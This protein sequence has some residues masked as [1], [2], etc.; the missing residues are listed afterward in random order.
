MEIRDKKEILALSNLS[1]KYKN[2]KVLENI[3]LSINKGEF[4]LLC[5]ESGSG[6]TTLLKVFNTVIPN[7]ENCDYEGEV[8]IAGIENKNL[9]EV[10]KKVSTVFQNPK[11]HF[12]N[13]DT[14]LELVFFLEN[15]GVKRDLIDEKIE[16][17]LKIFPIRHLL[18]RSIFNLS[19]G[20][21]Q[22]LAIAGAYIADT[23]IIIFDEPSANLDIKHIEILRTMLEKLKSLGK[24]III[25]EHRLW[26]LKDL[27]DRSIYIKN[28]KI[29]KEFSGKDF[30]ELSDEQR[31]E[32]GLKS[33]EKKNVDKRFFETVAKEKNKDEQNLKIKKLEYNFENKQILTISDLKYSFG[34]IIGIVGENGTG[35]STFLASLVGLEKKA[36]LDIEIEN[37]K[38]SKKE[39]I[40][41]S[42]LVMQDVNKQLFT[43]SVEQ[44]V[45]MNRELREDEINNVLKQMDLLD[46]KDRHPHSLSGGQN[47]ELLFLK[48]FYLRQKFYVL[49]SLQ[50]VWITRICS[51]YLN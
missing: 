22:I 31:K 50:V 7:Y 33:L 34:E 4:I 37:K 44:E 26:F 36:K 28:G 35:K 10:S 25:A 23:D 8:F 42:S 18:N 39:L 32:M 43:E 41:L 14:T 49:M 47:R 46:F 20:E 30:F 6:K 11:T 48:P 19:G 45:S 3:N 1:L 5:G 24:T 38:N 9:E 17:M 21:K 15:I 29:E 13:I 51:I 16:A 27:V 12:F 2:E 40:R